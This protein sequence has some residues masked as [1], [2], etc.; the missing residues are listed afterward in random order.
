MPSLNYLQ[1]M[2][3]RFGRG[4]N[5]LGSMVDPRQRFAQQ[6]Q[7]ES[8][9]TSPAFVGEGI[10][11][12]GKALVGALLAKR[13]MEDRADASRWLTAK[14]PDRTRQPTEA[15]ALADPK[16]EWLQQ[17]AMRG[18]PDVSQQPTRDKFATREYEDIL[19]DFRER[20]PDTDDVLRGTGRIPKTLAELS[21]L[22]YLQEQHKDFPEQTEFT[23]PFTGA[24]ET[25]TAED[26][27]KIPKRIEEGERKFAEQMEDARQASMKYRP[28]DYAQE[29]ASGMEAYRSAP[30]H[31]IS[32]PYTRMEWLRESAQGREANPFISR[33]LENLMFADMQREIAKEDIESARGFQTGEREA[34][35]KFEAGESELDRKSRE[36]TA[37]EKSVGL[38]PSNVREWKFYSNLP[39]DKQEAYL[40]MKRADKSFNIGGSVITPSQTDPTTLKGETATTL[41]PSEEPSYIKK[42]EEIKQEAKLGAKRTDDLIRMQP[43]AFSALG[44]FQQKT[45]FMKE[46][47]TQALNNISGWSTEFGAALGGWP[48]SQ[49]QALKTILNTIKANV[50]FQSLQEMRA[51]SPTGGALGQVSER[52]LAYLQATMGDIAQEQDGALLAE[53]L[54]AMQRQIEGM[55]ERLQ[56]AYDMTFTPLQ[57]NTPTTVPPVRKNRRNGD[58]PLGLGL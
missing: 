10:S 3:G 35:Q 44:A 40:T 2:A 46:N 16:L 7:M 22:N 24:K 57:G 12:L 13:S 33:M 26:W 51:N 45:N 50:G 25:A 53:K 37:L 27:V 55:G 29:L 56:Q 47:I 11:R 30:T 17:A 8:M 4:A 15:E 52:E 41:K 34:R 49:A 18:G 6:L 5:T 28:R 19:G 32:D 1:G 9:D 21:V 38:D 39:P 31:Q 58:D 43:K 42:A 54:R 36:K 20:V 14:M 48:G 23:H